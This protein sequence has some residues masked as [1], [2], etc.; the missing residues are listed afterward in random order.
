MYVYSYEERVFLF[1]SRQVYYCYSFQNPFCA[2][3]RNK[4]K[5]K[6]IKWKVKRNTQNCI[7]IKM[8]EKFCI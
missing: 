5:I 6:Q 8:L 2:R 1:L 7:I 4:L 3:V